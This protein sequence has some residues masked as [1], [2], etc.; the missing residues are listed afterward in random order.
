MA[1][2]RGGRQEHG[3]TPS[4]ERPFSGFPPDTPKICL[5]TGRLKSG[6]PRHLSPEPGYLSALLHRVYGDP[7]VISPFAAMA[8][9]AG[10]MPCS[11]QAGRVS[12]GERARGGVSSGTCRSQVDALGRPAARRPGVLRNFGNIG[13]SLEF[14]R[15]R[16]KLGRFPATDLAERGP[17]SAEPG[18]NF[19]FPRQLKS[20]LVNFGPQ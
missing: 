8:Y 12:T 7:R 6:N 10:T 16:A 18:P 17:S 13:P 19:P 2:I 9:G 5:C 20:K 15:F 3:P 1:K 4:L 14:G 11:A